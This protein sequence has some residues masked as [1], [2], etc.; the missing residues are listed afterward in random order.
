MYIPGK[1]LKNTYTFEYGTLYMYT[2][3]VVV[4]INEGEHVTIEMMI[5]FFQ[6]FLENYKIPFGYVSYRKNSYSIDPQVYK[7]LPKNDLLKGIAVVSTQKFS[8]LTALVEKKFCIG[9]YELFTTMDAAVNWL[10]EI[11][12]LENNYTSMSNHTI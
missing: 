4:E 7:M 3:L 9:R 1:Q 2:D 8:C 11:I 12:P 6:F 5:T 10:D